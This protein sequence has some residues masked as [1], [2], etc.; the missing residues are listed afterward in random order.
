[1]LVLGISGRKQSGKST[2]GNLI[3]SL[4]L[5]QLGLCDKI[6]MDDNSNIIISD[7]LGND[8][9]AGIFSLNDLNTNKVFVPDRVKI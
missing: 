2:V 3:L 4:H 1:M 7:L 5:A 8:S 6:Y 9:Y